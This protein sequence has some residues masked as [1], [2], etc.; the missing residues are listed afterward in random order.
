VSVTSRVP[1]PDGTGL[2]GRCEWGALGYPEDLMEKIF[3]GN[4][5]SILG[6]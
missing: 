5:E 1:C 6:L 3:H 4:A 2:Q